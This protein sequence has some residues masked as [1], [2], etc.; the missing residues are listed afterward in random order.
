MKV[1]CVIVA[2]NEEE[3]IENTIKCIINQTIEV[4]IVVVN[5]GSTDRTGNISRS[6]GVP[7]LSLPFHREN[8]TGT[9]YLAI[10]FNIGLDYIRRYN[11]DFVLIMGGDHI[12]PL[13][14]VESVIEQMVGPRGNIVIASGQIEGQP[15]IAPRGSGRIVNVEFWEKFNRMNYPVSPGWESWIVFKAL[16]EGYDVEIFDQPTSISRKTKASPR[17]MRGRGRGMYFLGYHP[18]Y[19]IARGV[20]IMLRRPLSGLA[21][22]RG[23]FFHGDDRKLDTFDYIRETQR[24]NLLPRIKEKLE[25]IIFVTE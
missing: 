5:D 10:R 7:V 17:K 12:L 20:L 14:Y 22:I 18:L 24:K 8:Y 3:R 6:F 19:A 21:M 11:P 2:R 4:K 16:M 23:Y 9:P 25:R 13:N 1:A 15:A